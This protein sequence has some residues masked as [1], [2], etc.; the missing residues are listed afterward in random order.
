MSDEGRLEHGHGPWGSRDPGGPDRTVTAKRAPRPREPMFNAPWPATALVGALV[1]SYAAQTWLGG[2]RDMAALAGFS[3]EDLVNGRWWTI[4][5]ALVIHASWMHVL[6]NALG[7]LIFGPPVARL[8]GPGLKAAGAFLL[9]FVVC[10]LIA[11][12]GWA[13]VHWGQPVAAVGASGAVFGLIGAASR[14][15]GRETGLSP[16]LSP[17]PVG[18][19][20]AFI[21]VNLLYGI[22]G[23]PLMEPGVVVAWEAH[24][25]GFIAG[26]LLVGP[27]ARTLGRA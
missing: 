20:A 9:F 18:M 4:L 2:G 14:L 19:A 13:A 23:T 6:S 11:S 3:P 15:Y 21:I 25:V 5:L 1:G 10:G 16:V 27:F 8:F 17:L 7:A 12:L 22:F 24:V 26:L